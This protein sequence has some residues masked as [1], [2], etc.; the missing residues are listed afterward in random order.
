[1]GEYMRVIP[2]RLLQQWMS[3]DRPDNESADRGYALV[4]VLDENSFEAEHIPASINIPLKD[5]EDFERRFSKDKEIIV[6]CES[7][8]SDAAAEA[9]RKLAA[10]GFTNVMDYAGGMRDWKNAGGEVIT[11]APE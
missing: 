8:D 11:G 2:H 10:R 3:R 7:P 4:N 6:Y 1:M 5:I 9:A